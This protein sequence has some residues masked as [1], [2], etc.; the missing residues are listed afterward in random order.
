MASIY[1]LTAEFNTLWALMDA[2][3]ISEDVLKEVFENTQEELAVK[4]EGYCKFI[5]N[6]QSDLA[7]IKEEIKRLNARKA[8]LENTIEHSKEAMKTA[9]EASG[10]K[11]LTCGTFKVSLANNPPKMVFDDTSVA[12][13]PKRYLIP[14]DPTIDKDAMKE[15]LTNGSDADKA[16]LEGIA[17]L[18]QGSH[19][20]IR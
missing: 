13:I 9:L 10:G 3:E 4:M 11:P 16:E 7:G 2:G 5:K 18:E 17:H 1:E 15:T 14:S 19:I 12:S 8:V 20:N 6:C